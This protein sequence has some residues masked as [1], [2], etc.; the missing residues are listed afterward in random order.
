MTRRFPLAV[1]ALVSASVLVV[2]VVGVDVAGAAKKPVRNGTLHCTPAAATTIAPSLVRTIPD[3]KPGKPGKDKPAKYTGAGTLSGCTG[4]TTG[5][6]TPASGT[7]TSS[8]KGPSR[9]CTSF[10]GGP[11]TITKTT[12]TLNTGDKLK[13]NSTAGAASVFDPATQTVTA[14]PTDPTERVSFILAH[15]TSRLSFVVTG[16]N[17]GKPYPGRTLETHVVTTETLNTLFVVGCAGTGVTGFSTDP[18]FSTFAIS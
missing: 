5:G 18:A 2:G 10:G 15:L 14:L 7:T 6:T 3:K 8:T 4:T 17:T 13:T 1:A 16:T 11:G 9:L 12:V